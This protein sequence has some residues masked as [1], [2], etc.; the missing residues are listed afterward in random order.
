MKSYAA[1]WSNLL[2]ITSAIMVI[3]SLVTIFG[4]SY[5][6]LNIPKWSVHLTR[7]TLPVIVIAC[8]PFIVLNY[9]IANKQLLIRRPFR[10]TRFDLTDFQSAAYAPKAMNKCLRLCGNGGIFSFTGWFW[11]STLGNFQAFVTDPNRTVVMRFKNKTIIVSPDDPE[12]FVTEL[13]S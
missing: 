7:W 11:N 13:N 9:S 5:L 12:A 10:T 6:P 2:K 1:P 3:L 4:S 8:V